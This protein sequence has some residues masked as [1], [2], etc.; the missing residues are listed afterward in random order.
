MFYI[1]F[2]LAAFRV[3]GAYQLWS[4]VFTVPHI[5]TAKMDRSVKLKAAAAHI[6]TKTFL[7]KK[8]RNLNFDTIEFTHICGD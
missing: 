2:G 8:I 1:P 5:V 6:I 4:T 3:T 7:F